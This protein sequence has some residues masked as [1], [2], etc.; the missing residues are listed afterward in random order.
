[1]ADMATSPQAVFTSF[2][3]PKPGLH[4]MPPSTMGLTPSSLGLTPS[5]MASMGLSLPGMPPASSPLN[6]GLGPLAGFHASIGGLMS[7]AG[8]PPGL[9]TTSASSP[10]ILSAPLGGLPAMAS[11]IAAAAKQQQQH[12]QQQAAKTEA[13]RSENGE[14]EDEEPDVQSVTPPPPEAP[15]TPPPTSSMTATPTKD[16]SSEDSPSKQGLIKARGTYYPL[17][18]FPTNMPQGPV[19]RRDDDSPPKTDVSSSG[20]K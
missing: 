3:L 10:N 19:M 15:A 2:K 16:S 14:R 20:K 9:I 13:A 17:T 11:Q 18:A 1:M 8:A 5:S 6:L 7:S 4:G 12:Q